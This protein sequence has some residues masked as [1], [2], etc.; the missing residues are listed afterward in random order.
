MMVLNMS[1]KSLISSHNMI[2]ELALVGKTVLEMDGL[3]MVSNW[4]L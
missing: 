2:T 1:L 4:T 3:N